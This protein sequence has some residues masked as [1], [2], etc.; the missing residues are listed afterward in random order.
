MDSDIRKFQT[1]ELNQTYQVQQ[2]DKIYK[3]PYGDSC[4]LLVSEE[5]SEETFELFA[6]KLLTKYI[7]NQKLKKRFNFTV[8]EKMVLN[9]QS[10]KATTRKNGLSWNNYL[11]FS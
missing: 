6:T 7:T 5:E 4:I 3:T 10:L 2:Y 1:L 8:K 11:S 9:I